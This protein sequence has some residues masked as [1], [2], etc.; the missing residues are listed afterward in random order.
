MLEKLSQEG[1]LPASH[2]D[3]HDFPTSAGERDIEKP[4]FLRVGELLGLGHDEVEERIVCD[5][6]REAVGPTL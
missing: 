5:L 6:A 1:G 3:Q 2:R 4:T